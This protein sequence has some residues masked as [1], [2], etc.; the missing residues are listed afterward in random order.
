MTDLDS[1]PFDVAAPRQPTGAGPRRHRHVWGVYPTRGLEMRCKFCDVIR[2]EVASRRGRQSRNYGNRAELDVARRYGGRKVGHAQG[3]TDVQG[4]TRKIQVK[5]SRRAVPA[6]WH[7]EFAKLKS[8]ADG[9]LAVLVL[10]FVRAG[11]LGPED[12][13]VIKA[14]DFIDWYG[15]DSEGET[16]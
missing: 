15:T 9:R 14:A 11:N 2:D 16:L 7:R 8:E 12:Y 3:P 6:M 10:R 1:M 13:F 5:T 4:M